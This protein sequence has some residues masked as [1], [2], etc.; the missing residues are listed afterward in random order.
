LRRLRRVELGALPGQL[1]GKHVLDGIRGQVLYMDNCRRSRYIRGVMRKSRSFQ[2]GEVGCAHCYHVVSRIVGRDLVLG[3]REKEH[4]R[5]LLDKH[6]RFSGV[7]VLA[8]CFMGNHFHLLL[9]VPDKKKAMEGW[10]EE[11]LLGRLEILADETSTAMAL[12][13]LALFRANGN[14]EGIT[15]I[16]ES[17][18]ARLFDLSVF[19]KEFKQKFTVW[20]N[21]RHRRV[22]TLWEGRF[23]SVLLEG[24]EAVRMVAAYIDLNPVRAGLAEDPKDYRWCSYAAAVGGKKRARRGLARAMGE[25]ERAA[26]GKVAGRYRLLLFGRG[27]EKPGGVTTEGREKRRLGFTRE[28]IETVW[29]TGGRL[30]LAAVL[31]CR[32]RYFTDGVVLGSEEYVDGF[33]EERREYFGPRRKT[34]ARKMRGADW[35]KVTVLRD[36]QERAVDMS[37]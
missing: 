36:L 1:C 27:E 15:A 10:T 35:G 32:V 13:Q 37:K 14:E 31:R 23:K 11:D 18:R 22:G 3:D 2:L 8:W 19:V 24:G 33:F 17:V 4:L 29:K 6:A 21:P 25:G 9:E 34:G 30:P 26:W 12:N 16:A 7:R 20:F 28:E 5:E